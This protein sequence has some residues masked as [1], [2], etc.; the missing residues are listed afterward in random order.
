MSYV[1]LSEGDFQVVYPLGL[2]S[3][4]SGVVKVPYAYGK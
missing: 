1:Q 3:R 4:C 2:W